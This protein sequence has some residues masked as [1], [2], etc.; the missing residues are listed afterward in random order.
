LLDI[1]VQGSRHVKAK[2]PDAISIFLLPPGGRELASRLVGRGSEDPDRQRRRL[3]AARDEIRAATE[4]DYV[5]VND[6]LARAVDSL[7]M[8]LAAE[9]LCSS[10]IAD[11]DKH[12]YEL[13]DEIDQVLGE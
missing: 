3:N 8:I 13:I 9:S 2:V 10:R 7:E 6:D 4:F 1:D 11:L 5:I 12:L